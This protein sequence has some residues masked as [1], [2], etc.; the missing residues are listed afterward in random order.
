MTIIGILWF[1]MGYRKN[2][3]LELFTLKAIGIQWDI[4]GIHDVFKCYL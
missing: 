4:T 3:V 1:A 2:T